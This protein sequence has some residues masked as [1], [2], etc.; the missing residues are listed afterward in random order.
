MP[1]FQTPKL[2]R[3]FR[4]NPVTLYSDTV[5]ISHQPKPCQ[6]NWVMLIVT[7]VITA[8]AVGP[9]NSWAGEKT[10]QLGQLTKSDMALVFGFGSSRDSL[11]L[12]GAGTLKAKIQSGEAL[13]L[14]TDQNGKL[15]VYKDALGYSFYR[16]SSVDGNT[17]VDRALIDDRSTPLPDESLALQ[18]TQALT[19][20]PED[21]PQ[22]NCL[23]ELPKDTRVKVLSSQYFYSSEGNSRPPQLKNYLLVVPESA[24]PNE[25]G[26]WTEAHRVR[27]Q[28][29][30]S[31]HQAS[32]A[33]AALIQDC[34]PKKAPLSGMA[35]LAKHLQSDEENFLDEIMREV[36]VCAPYAKNGKKYIELIDNSYLFKGKK[37]MGHDI[38]AKKLQAI[39]LLSRSLNAEMASCNRLGPHYMNA[40][41]KVMRNR[42]RYITSDLT[43][44]NDKR[45]FDSEKLLPAG[46]RRPWRSDSKTLRHFILERWR[47]RRKAG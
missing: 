12:Q 35:N 41:A 43:S 36:G 5:K 25:P 32:D 24:G 15:V 10:V 6:S 47:C 13:S 21:C 19:Q 14:Q 39:D 3:H 46:R 22:E 17:F 8:F 26:V 40:V 44:E 27:P 18:G 45:E 29:K 34:E 42:V 9:R 30:R 2:T 37:I 1:E 23:T 31:E 16:V 28:V 11:K 7:F 20:T 4:F 33:I 38:P